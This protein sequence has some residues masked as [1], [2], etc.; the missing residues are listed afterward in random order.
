M[1]DKD[2]GGKVSHT[3]RDPTEGTIL[4]FLSTANYTGDGRGGG[5]TCLKRTRENC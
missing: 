3:K 2:G 4:P 1:V 5:G